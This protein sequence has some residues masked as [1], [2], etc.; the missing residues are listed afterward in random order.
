VVF[1]SLQCA[2]T[3]ASVLQLPDFDRDF[4][5]ECNASGS[6][7]GI[8][9]HQGACPIAFFSRQLAPLHSKLAAY[10]RELIGLVRAVHHRR[11]YLWGRP[12]M[13][14][15]DDFSLKYLLDQRLT[16]IPQHQWASTL[17]GFDFRVEFRPG[18][19]NVVANALSRRDTEEV[20]L[21][22]ALSAPSF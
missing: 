4:T 9:L 15:I 20:A 13:I 14:M 10:E 17:I 5:V 6:G 11:P 19:S 1:R 2:L 7:V 3:L 21:A 18:M 8:V 22:M 16:A 12:F